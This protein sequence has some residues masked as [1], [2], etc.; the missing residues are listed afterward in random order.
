MTTAAH[1]PQPLDAAFSCV[2]ETDGAFPTYLELPGSA[3]VLGTRRAVKVAG[4]LDGHPFAATLMPSGRGPHWLP[5]RKALCARIGKS[6]A[7]APV[8]VHLEQRAG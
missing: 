4:T 8:L 3:E 1:V 7:G 6:E 2:I 5:L